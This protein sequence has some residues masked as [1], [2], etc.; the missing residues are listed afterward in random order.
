MLRQ[1][2]DVVMA[3][4]AAV[5]D[6]VRIALQAAHAARIDGHDHI[7]LPGAQ[8]GQ[9]RFLLAFAIVQ[10]DPVEIGEALA[11]IGGVALIDR[12]AVGVG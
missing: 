4:T 1:L 8:P 5:H 11:P 6:Q 10:L 3:T 7:E 12:D 9:C 2:D